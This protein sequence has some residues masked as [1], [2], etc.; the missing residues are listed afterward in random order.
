MHSNYLKQNALL[1]GRKFAFSFTN[2]VLEFV[3]KN[4]N[5][6]AARHLNTHSFR[7]G[8][9][10]FKGLLRSKPPK[11]GNSSANARMRKSGLLELGANVSREFVMF[12]W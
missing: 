2:S 7:A 11:T 9:K 12:F 1:R 3:V 6:N 10:T 5:S 8:F 4:L